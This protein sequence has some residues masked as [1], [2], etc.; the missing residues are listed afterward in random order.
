MAAFGINL[1]NI[2]CCPSNFESGVHATGVTARSRQHWDRWDSW[3]TKGDRPS[4][5]DA[6]VSPG[7][8]PLEMKLFKLSQIVGDSWDRSDTIRS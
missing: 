6:I 3:D 4:P 7:C 1:T 5:A 2:G 8:V